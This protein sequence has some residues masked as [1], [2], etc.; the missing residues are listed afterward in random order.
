MADMYFH[1]GLRIWEFLHSY[2]AS[3]YTILSSEL[4]LR[5]LLKPLLSEMWHLPGS[6]DVPVLKQKR[7]QR[8]I[9][10]K[11][12][13]KMKPMRSFINLSGVSVCRV[14]IQYQIN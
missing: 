5:T 8:Y 12:N 6:K 10:D 13:I 4:T 11:S 3:M 1:S 2:L 9:I 14:L 7:L